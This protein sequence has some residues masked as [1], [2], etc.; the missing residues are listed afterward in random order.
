M[1]ENLV[2]WQVETAPGV[3]DSPYYRAVFKKP[4]GA[5]LTKEDAEPIYS[6]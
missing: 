6:K 1:K 3:Y 5:Q 4:Y 2:S